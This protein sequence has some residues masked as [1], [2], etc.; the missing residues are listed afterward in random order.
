MARRICRPARPGG[1]GPRERARRRRAGVG[2]RC[3]IG[4]SPSRSGRRP[5]TYCP[6]GCCNSAG[7]RLIVGLAWLQGPARRAGHP[8]GLGD[9]C[10]CG[11]EAARDERPG[12]LRPHRPARFRSYAQ[13]PGRGVRC[14][15][16]TRF[17]VRALRKAGQNPAGRAWKESAFEHKHRYRRICVPRRRAAASQPVRAAQAAPL[18]T[19]LLD[20]VLRRRQR[21]PVQVRVHGDGDLPAAGRL[22]AA[23]NGRPGDRRIVHP[24]VPAVLCHQRPAGGQ[25]RQDR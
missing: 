23:G 13:A 17:V 2:G 25:I 3:V 4:P 5:A 22:A 9:P 14:L 12:D 8:P 15:A 16:S 7:W 19:L 21:Q 24:P 10:L 18:R 1:R 20:P 11:G 6:G